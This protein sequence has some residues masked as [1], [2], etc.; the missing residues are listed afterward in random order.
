M[1][2]FTYTISYHG[3]H[4]GFVHGASDVVD[5]ANKALLDFGYCPP[6]YRSIERMPE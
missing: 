3:R 5:A 2:Y 1:R 6:E 4:M